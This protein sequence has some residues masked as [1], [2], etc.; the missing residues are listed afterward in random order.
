MNHITVNIHCLRKTSP[1]L[2]LRYLCQISSDFA[3]FWAETSPGN[4]KQTNIH[5]HL[6]LHV[7]TVPCKNYSDASERTLRRR[8]LPIRLVIELESHNF[9][10][11]LFKPLTFQHLSENSRI[12]LLA[13]KPLMHMHFL[14][15]NPNFSVA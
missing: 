6:V 1:F 8:P 5:R 10:K 7:C 2:L 14:N 15:Q 3:H 11:S 13:Q 12:N 9:F 4:L